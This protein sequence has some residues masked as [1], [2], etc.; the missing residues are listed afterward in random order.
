MYLS[1]SDD[2]WR[3]TYKDPHVDRQKRMQDKQRESGRPNLGL[4]KASY[5]DHN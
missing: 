4:G 1:V 2:S 3:K 5:H